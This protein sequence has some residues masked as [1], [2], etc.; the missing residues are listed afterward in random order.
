MTKKQI[1][2]DEHEKITDIEDLP[3]DDTEYMER[4]MKKDM[5]VMNLEELKDYLDHIIQ[6]R[7]DVELNPAL[8][9]VFSHIQLYFRVVDLQTNLVL[10]RANAAHSL[11][12]AL[13]LFIK[14][15]FPDS[16]EDILTVMDEVTKEKDM[17]MLDGLPI[18]S[19]ESIMKK[20]KALY[21]QNEH[22]KVD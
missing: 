17:K 15:K 8:F 5:F 9:D 7:I 14:D 18:K 6:G 16:Y 2:D 19:Q 22:P 20:A 10:A 3:K 13:A 21:R 12:F 11:A 4:L 1:T